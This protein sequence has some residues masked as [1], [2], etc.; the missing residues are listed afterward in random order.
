M[1]TL[2]NSLSQCAERAPQ[3]TDNLG[4]ERHKNARAQALGVVVLGHTQAPA[5]L[6][7]P[8]CR[9]QT[10]LGSA[11][12]GEIGHVDAAVSRRRRSLVKVHGVCLDDGAPHSA[13]Q[14]VDDH[15]G[16]EETDCPV[17]VGCSESH[18]SEGG[19]ADTAQST[20]RG[21][22]PSSAAACRLE[23]SW[24]TQKSPATAKRA[25]PSANPSATAAVTAEGAKAAA[26]RAMAC[27]MDATVCTRR[28]TSVALAPE[29]V[30]ESAHA[31]AKPAAAMPARGG[32]KEKPAA[33]ARVHPYRWLK[34][35]GSHASTVNFP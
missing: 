8:G 16:R 21:G 10:L 33:C 31:D 5:C 23:M 9:T 6:C 30:S 29:A 24:C 35:V 1:S 28:R 22:E 14:Q 32:T 15:N 34:K 2:L 27:P 4:G 7:L 20:H 19:A 11:L 13:P 18:S 17:V 3:D 26:E 25:E 12:R